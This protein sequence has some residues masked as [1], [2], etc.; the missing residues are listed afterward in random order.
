MAASTTD[1]TTARDPGSR[2]L[3]APTSDASAATPAR[4]PGLRGR[5][6]KRRRER[7]LIG[8]AHLARALEIDAQ[9]LSAVECEGYR[10][11]PRGMST[12]YQVALAVITG[13]HSPCFKKCGCEGLRKEHEKGRV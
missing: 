6:L 7:L 2:P 4:Y 13:G 12:E 9:K 11:L 8:Q 10:R 5:A 1:T 3:Q